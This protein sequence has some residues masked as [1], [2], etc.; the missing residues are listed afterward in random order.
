VSKRRR[1]RGVCQREGGLEGCVKEEEYQPRA[2][3]PPILT[4]LCGVC[5][6]LHEITHGRVISYKYNCVGVVPDL[7]CDK[8]RLLDYTYYTLISNFRKKK[9]NL[10]VSI[11][12][13]SRTV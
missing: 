2:T 6:R 8:T 5:L 10:I 11:V 1:V 9:D 13:C 3:H 12:F 4:F 7:Y